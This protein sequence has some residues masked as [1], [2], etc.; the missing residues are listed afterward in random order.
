MPCNLLLETHTQ[1]GKMLRGWTYQININYF[2]S[3]SFHLIWSWSR[4]HSLINYWKYPCVWVLSYMH[5]VMRNSG[6]EPPQNAFT[7]HSL[8]SYY[9][10]PELKKRSFSQLKMGPNLAFS[11]SFWFDR[12]SNEYN[13][14]LLMSYTYADWLFTIGAMITLQHRYSHEWHSNT[15]ASISIRM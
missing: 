1:R 14:S 7:C 13:V 4:K 5:V 3:F 2:E 8:F 15:V 9:S 11:P 12:S 6:D 10:Y